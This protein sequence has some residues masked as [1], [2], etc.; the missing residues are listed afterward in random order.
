[1]KHKACGHYIIVQL[2]KALSVT[3]GGI[4][5]PDMAQSVPTQ[6]TVKSVGDKVENF[7]K[8]QIVVFAEYAAKQLTDDNLAVLED[9]AIFAVLEDEVK[10]KKKTVSPDDGWE[11]AE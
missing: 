3:Q 1:M 5:L 8:G 7:K 4:H 6:G 2:P 10:I 11:I 9:K